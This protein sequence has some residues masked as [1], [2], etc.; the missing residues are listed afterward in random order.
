MSTLQI[1][2]VLA[3][4]LALLA[5]LWLRR[6]GGSG[7]SAAPPD[8]IDTLIGWPPTPTRLL[9]GPQRSAM[10]TLVLA[11]PEYM[12]LAQVPLSRFI[13]VP[14]RNSY[15]D[16]LRRVGNQCVDFLVCDMAAHV[17]AVVELQAPQASERARK[18]LARIAR[19]LKAAKIPIHL[20]REDALPSASA[21][22][23][24][25]LPRPHTD[26]IHPRIPGLAVAAHPDRAGPPADRVQAEPSTAPD[27]HAA[28]AWAA[29]DLVDMP[30]PP[31]STW[32]DD[33]DAA[34]AP[35]DPPK[36]SKR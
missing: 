31:P 14:K 26:S 35:M 5:W 20:W 18:R 3:V 9:S 28:G 32:F 19:T 25:I 15:A 2:L 4:V 21:A 12:V 29:D 23:D 13:S 17:V 22:R 33:L 1:G 11:L 8:R 10:N 6:R 7:A 30:E 27:N 16:W 24:A 34:P 36:R